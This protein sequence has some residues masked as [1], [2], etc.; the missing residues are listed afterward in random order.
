M[1]PKTRGATTRA[2]AKEAAAKEAA[3]MEE[4][5]KAAEKKMTEALSRAAQAAKASAGTQ[6]AAGKDFILSNWIIRDLIKS[7]IFLEVSTSLVIAMTYQTSL[8][9]GMIRNY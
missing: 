1:S 3:A 6:R 2:A 8:S 7:L 9:V 5:S 4:Q